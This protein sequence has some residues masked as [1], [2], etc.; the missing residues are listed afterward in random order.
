MHWYICIY[1][2]SRELREG[3]TV[4]DKNGNKVGTS[5]TAA[6]GAITQVVTSRIAMAMPG[7][8]KFNLFNILCFFSKG[9]FSWF[10]RSLLI[11][12]VL[13]S[14]Y[15]NFCLQTVFC[16]CTLLISVR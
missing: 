14:Y 16:S 5:K 10:S 2:L 11:F 6:K 9:E 3:I 4:T 12:E 15:P 7:M 8:C 1:L 13:L